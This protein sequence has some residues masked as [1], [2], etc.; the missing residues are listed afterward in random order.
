MP[1]AVSKAGFLVLDKPADLT[2]RAAVDHAELWF[3][4]MKLGHAGTLDPAATGVLVIG[5]GSPATRLLE[6]VQEQE[7]VYQ[8]T[9]VLGATS[10]TDDA[11]GT[12]TPRTV[13]Q[14]PTPEELAQ[15]L[16]R[17]V[18]TISQTPPAYS[19][20]LVAG[21]RAYELARQ[22][23]EVALPPR[24]VVIY[25]LVLRRY[26]YPELDVEIR[27]GKGTYVRSIARDLGEALQT[28]AYVKTLRRTRIGPFTLVDAVPWTASQ[29]E[30]QAA[31]LPLLKAISGF[32]QANLTDDECRRICLGQGIAWKTEEKVAAGEVALLDS[33]NEVIG[34]G[35]YDPTK[36][37]LR[38]MKIFRRP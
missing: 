27:C 19:A 17:L 29:S 35:D 36:H 10:I 28:G 8:S 24:P 31:M 4:S 12:L 34:L 11:E 14:L 22:G 23:K 20:A 13:T 30:A 37:L 16:Q 2:S 21:T 15:Q 33:K 5:V 9:F 38:P 32:A 18:G 1:S 7:K 25:A 6:C 3:P 26:T